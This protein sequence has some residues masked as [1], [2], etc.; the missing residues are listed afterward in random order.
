MSSSPRATSSRFTDTTQSS[1]IDA[2]VASAAAAKNTTDKQNVS[3]KYLEQIVALLNKAA[4][5]EVSEKKI[6]EYEHNSNSMMQQGRVLDVMESAASNSNGA[7]QGFMGLGMM[8]MAS[9]GMN[10]AVMTNAFS[11][12]NAQQPTSQSATNVESTEGAVF[13]PECGTKSNGGKF[14]TNC[15][16]KLHD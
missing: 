14:C 10:S 11:N 15:G 6:N 3:D 1:Y 5:K 7:A 2:A 9:G 13:C 12:N 16:T 4:G 8:N